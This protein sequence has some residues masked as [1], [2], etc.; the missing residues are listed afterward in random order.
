M[1]LKREWEKMV[2]SEGEDESH[3][4]VNLPVFPVSPSINDSTFVCT[5]AQ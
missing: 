2:V 4:R 1:I 3:S 5:T